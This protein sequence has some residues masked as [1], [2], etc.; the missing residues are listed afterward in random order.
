MGRGY[1]SKLPSQSASGVGSG[2]DHAEGPYHLY[3]KSRTLFD[4]DLQWVMADQHFVFQLDRPEFWQHSTAVH[5]GDKTVPG[6][7]P[8]DLLIVLCVHGSKHAWEQLKWVCDVAELLRANHLLD[9]NYIF[10]SASKWR[11]TRLVLM[12]LSLAH[13]RLDVA[14]PTKVLDQLSS[15]PDLDMLCCRMPSTLLADSHLGVKETQAVALYFSLKD[16]WW[17]RWRFGLMLCRDD[18][19]VVRTPP[20]WFQWRISL[21]R[22]ALLVLPFHRAMR[23]V[24]PTALRG[25]I[26]RWLEQP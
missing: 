1:E 19:P 26:N 14:L 17:E 3:R 8:E 16:S 7:S 2:V 9:W 20:A 11:C 18:S 22:L 10:L 15:N 4:V 6:L 5:L 13:H 25:S 12:G 23:S 21:S 24:F